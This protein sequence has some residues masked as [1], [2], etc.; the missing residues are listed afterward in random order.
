M[1]PATASAGG[2]VC[3][4]LSIKYNTSLHKGVNRVFLY[5]PF[6]NINKIFLQVCDP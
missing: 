6:G 2:P 1:P 5:T 3:D 4:G